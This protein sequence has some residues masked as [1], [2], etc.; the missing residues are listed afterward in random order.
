MVGGQGGL[1]GHL[2]VGRKARIGAQAGVM[3][4]VPAGAD[5][6]GSPAMPLKEFFRNVAALRKLAAGQRAGQTAPAAGGEAA[7]DGMRSR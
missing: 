2:R 1:T 6:V 4:D 7:A 5:V 3:S